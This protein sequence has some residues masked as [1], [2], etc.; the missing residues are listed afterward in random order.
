MSLD[1][2]ICDVVFII[3]QN[4]NK[5]F[6]KSFKDISQFQF[7]LQCHIEMLFNSAISKILCSYIAT[8]LLNFHGIF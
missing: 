4:L 2:G 8:Y 7:P 3:I 5:N 6:N 1:L